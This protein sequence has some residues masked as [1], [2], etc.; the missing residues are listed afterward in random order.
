MVWHRQINTSNSR[1]GRGGGHFEGAVIDN[2][3]KY[4]KVA[5]INKGTVYS[6]DDRALIKNPRYH[7]IWLRSYA[8][9]LGQ[10]AKGVQD[11]KGTYTIIFIK[12][13]EIPQDRWKNVTYGRIVVDYLPQKSEPYQTRLT[14]GGDKINY[15]YGVST[16]TVD[17][18]TIKLL[19]NS[20][21]STPGAN[22]YIMDVKYFYL[23]TPMQ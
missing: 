23:I 4:F 22:F 21:I 19:W 10:L 11:I 1:N 16:P 15:P 2:K 20:T 18:T 5:V 8:N 13:N 17:L 9:E 14:V 3:E 6:L 7:D 12:K